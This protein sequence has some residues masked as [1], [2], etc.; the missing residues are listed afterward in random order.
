MIVDKAGFDKDGS[1]RL[2]ALLSERLGD[3]FKIISK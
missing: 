3:K 1:N 2:G